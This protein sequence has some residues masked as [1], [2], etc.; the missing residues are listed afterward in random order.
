MEKMGLA[1]LLGHSPAMKEVREFVVKAARVRAPVLLLG[2]TGTGK[3]LIGKVI[4]HESPRRTG[5]YQAV[6]CAGIPA[7]LFE[8][9]F[10]GHNR[11][12]FTGAR[13]ARRG[14]LEQ[15]SGGTLFLDEV[16][17]LSAGQQ[18]KL[19]TALEEGEIRRLGGEGT[20]RVDFRVLAATARNL[21]EGMASGAFRR[22]L[23]H[24][25]SLLMCTVPP[26][27]ERVEDIPLLARSFLRVHQRR[28]GLPAHPLST[29]ALAYLRAEPWP[30]NVRE[31]SHFLEAALIL[32][33]DGVLTEGQLRR[34][35]GRSALSE[36]AASGPGC[37]DDHRTAERYA[38]HGSPEEER[39]HVL[40][41]LRRCQG[42]KSRAAREL[43][44][45]RNTLRSRLEKWAEE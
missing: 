6:N 43:G 23:F 36:R 44:M 37:I 30:G 5:A 22:D 32:S 29:R 4:H 19:L 7:A 27:R 8:S 25:L 11:G 45:S 38:Y 2:E 26:L 3:S 10:F 13:E 31:L 16:G 18:A 21:E 34:V 33:E 28:H 1:D 24:R 15:A 35:K 14:I 42:N 12:A 41:A 9:E 17:E 40:D 20:R 39:A